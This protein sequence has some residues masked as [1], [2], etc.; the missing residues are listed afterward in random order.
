MYKRG[1]LF[2]TASTCRKAG[3]GGLVKK[4]NFDKMRWL[5]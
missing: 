3:F 5:R 2:T 4:P 1:L